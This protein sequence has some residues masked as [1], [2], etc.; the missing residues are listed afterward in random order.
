MECF[1]EEP[2]DLVEIYGF[3]TDDKSAMS[4]KEAPTAFRVSLES[5]FGLKAG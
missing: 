4:G 1:F 5:E 2:R 3:V